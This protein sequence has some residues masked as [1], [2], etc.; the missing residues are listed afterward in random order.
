M[1]IFNGERLV[2]NREH[3]Q[4]QA[5]MNLS[6]GGGTPG[7][8][9]GGTA[10]REG[11]LQRKEGRKKEGTQ[12]GLRT[13]LR[14]EGRTQEGRLEGRRDSDRKKEGGKEKGRKVS[15][16]KTGRHEGR[17]PGTLKGSRKTKNQNKRERGPTTHRPCCFPPPIQVWAHVER[18]AGAPLTQ[19]PRHNNEAQP[20]AKHKTTVGNADR[21]DCMSHMLEHGTRPAN[22]PLSS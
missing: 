6:M 11:V 18:T 2:K 22:T 4:Q 3:V 14:K 12:E 20:T 21:S 10:E 17:K 7:V 9:A 19:E 16:G 5:L 8:A 13:K 1:T 15:K